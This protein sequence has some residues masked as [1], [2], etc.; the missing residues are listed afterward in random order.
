AYREIDFQSFDLLER[1]RV[2][3]T[4]IGGSP[5]MMVAWMS[6]VVTIQLLGLLWFDWLFRRAASR[7][8]ADVQRWI[9]LPLAIGATAGA[10]LA[11]FQG[12]V[13]IGFLSGGVWPSMGRAAGSLLDANSFGMIAA[14]W[15]AG[16]LA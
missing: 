3:N 1:Y 9:A 11:L 8:P 5:T 4:G 16:L 14:M 6:D 2:S 15:S 7:D 12:A 13:N 10:A